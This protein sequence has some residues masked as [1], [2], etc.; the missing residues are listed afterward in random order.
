MDSLLSSF[1]SFYRLIKKNTIVVQIEL[2]FYKICEFGSI[3]YLLTDKYKCKKIA[4]LH[5]HIKQASLDFN[6]DSF[7]CIFTTYYFNIYLFIC[8][9]SHAAADVQLFVTY[10]SLYITYQ[11]CAQTCTCVYVQRCMYL[12]MQSCIYF[13]AFFYLFNWQSL[14]FRKNIF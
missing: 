8:N 5:I 2:F 3:D 12:Y 13:H 9:L 4:Y 1:N 11:L 7:I 10:Q 6:P 14:L